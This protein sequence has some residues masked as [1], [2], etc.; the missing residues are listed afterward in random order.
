MKVKIIEK[1]RPQPVFISDKKTISGKAKRK[2]FSEKMVAIYNLKKSK[3]IDITQNINGGLIRNGLTAIFSHIKRFPKCGK[4]KY[5]I[6]RILNKKG[7]VIGYTVWR[8]K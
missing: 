8:I 1:I 5:S 6:Q 2:P 4:R 3:S 7:E